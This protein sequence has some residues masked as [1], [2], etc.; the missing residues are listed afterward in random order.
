VLP[1]MVPWQSASAMCSVNIR[2][3]S[4]PCYKWKIECAGYHGS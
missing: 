1:S 4:N 3:Y 2:K